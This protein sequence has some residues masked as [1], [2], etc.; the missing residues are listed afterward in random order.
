M[1]YRIFFFLAAALV[2][3]GIN[4]CGGEGKSSD[5]L[6]TD[7]LAFGDSSGNAVLQLDLN[8]AVQLTATV[9]D[10]A[11]KT[12]ADREVFFD[13]V[14]N[15]SGATISLT[16]VNTSAA[17]E[18]T[19]LY[20]A[21]GSPG[22]D[23]VRAF[24]SNG[25][26]MDVSIT[27]GGGVGG[28][29]V[30]LAAA[31]TSLTV[32]QSSILT[33]TVTNSTGSPVKGQTVTFALTNNNSGA[34]LTTL[35]GITDVSGRAIAVYTAGT[36]NPTASVEDIVQASVTGSVAAV[37]IT[38][39]AVGGVQISLA[40]APTSLA[41]GQSSILTATVT[42]S[43]G[44]PVTGQTAAFAFSANRSGATLTI[45]N[46][47]TDVSGRAIAVYTAGTANPTASVEDVVQAGVTGSVSAVTITRT[48]VGG[49]QISLAAAPTSLA[50]GQNSILTATVT[51]SAGSPVAGQTVAFAFS[52]NRSGAALITLNGTT[53]I[54]GRAIAVYT[55]GATNPT[56][57][58]ED[59]VQASVAGSS[60]VGA[61]V[62][63]RTAVA[64]GG[65]MTLSIASSVTS[66]AAG[67]IA[68]ITA[69]VT[70]GASSPVSGQAVTFTLSTNRSAATLIILSG[71]TDV[72]GRAV[73]QYTAGANSPTTSVQDTVLASVPGSAA[74]AVITRTVGVAAGFQIGVTATPASLVAGATSI[75]AAQVSNADGTAAAGQ[76]VTFGF[77]SGAPPSGATLS[78]LNSGRTDAGGKALAIYTAGSLSPGQSIQDVVSAS[79]PG[80]VAAAI[81]TRLATSGAGNR[82]SS[83]TAIPSTLTTAGGSSIITATVVGGDNVTPIPGE[84]V[85]FTVL[86]GV[87]SVTPTAV[88][89]NNGKANAVFTGTGAIGGSQSVVRAQILGGDA[90][91]I[92]TWGP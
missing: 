22:F 69:T 1:R 47:T 21:G 65:G 87:G 33:A 68:V 34:T 71:T 64:G 44:N 90:V 77:I 4:G 32:G 82:I 66:L 92:I 37:T 63:T 41:A 14:P 27:V 30:S 42:D 11:G 19:L 12:V 46:G 2:A 9:K 5:P 61:V 80:A 13:V 15:G 31:P 78:P 60:S 49:V 28:G 45:L 10:A 43:A 3:L 67:Q 23:V 35:N 89:G 39:T 73:A 57:S 24:I 54:S 74:A 7:S 53:D 81:I 36:A 75:I 18:A 79:V 16:K 86:T 25:V 59:T 20:K 72:S 26:R 38:R 40:A 83:L 91:V 76:T 70:D 62:I 8:G 52:A 88:T 55:A 85:T 29:Q 17:G 6:G 58:I 56:S 84:T 50:T 51:D 48:A